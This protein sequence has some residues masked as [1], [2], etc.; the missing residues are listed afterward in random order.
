MEKYTWRAS[1]VV[2]KKDEYI[3]RHEQIW[4]E[5]VTVLK[6]AGICNYTIWENNNELFGYYECEKGIEFAAKVQKESDVVDR[7]NEYMKDVLIMDIDEK[8]GLQPEMKKVFEL[9]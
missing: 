4:P 6:E 2:G 9:D 8:T 5:M 1:I 3:K 7:W